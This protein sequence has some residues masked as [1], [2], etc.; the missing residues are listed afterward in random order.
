MKDKYMIRIIECSRCQS[1][2]VFKHNSMDS[3]I[4]V[5]LDITIDGGYMMFIDNVFEPAINLMLCH[6]CAHEFTKFMGIPEETVTR[7]HPKTED[8][9]CNGW[10]FDK[11]REKYLSV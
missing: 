7:W 9:F 3:E 10:R 2:Q 1:P 6:K 8:L 4:P 11:E 5:A